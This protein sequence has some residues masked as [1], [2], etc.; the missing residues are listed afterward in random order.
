[1]PYAFH[2]GLTLGA[3][4]GTLGLQNRDKVTI[5][6][7][8]SIDHFGPWAE[9]LIAESLGKEGRGVVPVVN[10]SVGKPHDYSSDRL[11]VYLRVDDDSDISEMDA[12][13]RTLRE[14]GHPRVT[15][16]LA[17]PYA[18]FGEFFR[19]EFATAV[20]GQIIKVNPFDEPNVTE[21]KE[22]T[23]EI[24]N[25]VQEHGHLPKHAPT[26]EGNTVEVYIDEAHASALR[27]VG[28]SHSYDEQSRTEF[29]AAQFAG[30]HAGDYFALLAYLTPTAETEDSLRT[31]ARR[32]R[33]V[34]KRAV[35]IGFGPRYLHSTGQLHKGGPATGIFIQFTREIDPSQDIAIP[36]MPYTFGTL[37]QAQAAGDL[38]TLQKHGLRAIRIHVKQD[39]QDGLD[40]ILAAIDFVAQRRQ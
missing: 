11:F 10:N 34:T 30:T 20:A 36:G 28:R 2:P 14:A 40:K 17:D 38:A 3:V 24:L 31:A 7:T 37:F 33:H 23:K 35:T 13:I 26:I 39:L 16:R 18:L 29:L 22:A 27:E 1:V 6:G 21:A 9:Q 32:L 15:L 25:Y 12:G 8:Q 5:R 4:I 19:W